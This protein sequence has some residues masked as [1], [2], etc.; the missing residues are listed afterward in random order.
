VT[1]DLIALRL[2]LMLL[3]NKMVKLRAQMAND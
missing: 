2:A 1:I 3:L